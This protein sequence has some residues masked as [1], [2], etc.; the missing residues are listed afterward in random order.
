MPK[1]DDLVFAE[2]TN[3]PAPTTDARKWKLLVV[4]DDD[5]VHKVTALVLEDYEFDGNG[6]ELISAYSAEQG[7]T[8]LAEHP[9]TA[10][11]LLDVVMETSHAGLDM[12]EWVRNELRNPLVRIILRTGQPG[13]APEQDVIFKYDINDYKEKSELTSRKLVTTVSTAI[14]SYRDIRTIERHRRGL[15]RIVAAS[16]TIFKTQSLGEFASGVLQQLSSTV[17]LDDDTIIARAAGLAATRKGDDFEII[18]STGRFEGARGK[19]LSAVPDESAVAAIEKAVEEKRSFFT[20]DAFVGY[21]K[22]LR[23]S[24]SIIYLGGIT[25]A[26]EED[27][28]LIEIFSTNI[29]A[30]FDNIDLNTMVNEA[31]KELLRVLGE[32]METRSAESTNHV[33]R[34]SE[35]CYLL[36]LKA[37]MS[38]KDADTLRTASL[39]HDAGKIAIPDSILL[40]PDTLTPDEFELMKQHTELGHDVLKEADSPLMQAAATVALEHHERWDGTGYPRGLC[41]EEISLF[42]R[43]AMLADVFDALGCSRAYRE[44]WPLEDILEFITEHKGSLFDPNLVDSFL[45]GL[46]EIKAIRERFPDD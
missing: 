42:G 4:D 19:G 16:P 46:D 10:V 31:Q 39:V 34:V 5:F 40:K 21:Y 2:E 43:M 6:I 41:G 27:Q 23:G 17:C 22:T 38:E 9:D 28:R 11:I 33:R 37:G 1:N 44:A 25:L 14:R 24:E 45:E 18:A 13:E 7:M 3:N 12:A 20:D 15:A 26:S 36:A 32:A 8:A 35:Y 29:A 30:A